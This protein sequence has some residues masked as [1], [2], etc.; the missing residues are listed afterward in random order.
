MMALI[1]LGSYGEPLVMLFHHGLD[2]SETGV[3]R[4]IPAIVYPPINV[5]GAE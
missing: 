2:L 5:R 3:T 1:W 4:T